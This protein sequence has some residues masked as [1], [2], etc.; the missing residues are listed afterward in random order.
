MAQ[1]RRVARAAARR[2]PTAARRR[3]RVVNSVRSPSHRVVD[4]ALVG[5]EHLLV[6]GRVSPS[7]NCMLAFSSCIPGAGALA[8]ERQRELAGLGEVEGQVVGPATPT[9]G[10]AGTSTCG[11]SRNAMLITRAPS[12]MHLPVRRK[13]GTP[14]QRQLSTR[15]RSGDERLDL[16]VRRDARPRRGSPRTARARRRRGGSA[17]GSGRPWASRRRAA[18]GSS[19][20]GG[21][22]ATTA[23]I[24]SRCV[25]T[26]SRNAPVPS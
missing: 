2:P 4:Q 7:E 18:R 6:L 21:S 20:G 17:A 23:R 9:P 15:T 16:G 14:A 22:I 12:A 19:D 26:M 11:G 8:V 3:R 10:P 13:N 24:C 5:L 1:R 25:T